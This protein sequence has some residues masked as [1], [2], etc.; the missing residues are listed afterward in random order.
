MVNMR[1]HELASKKRSPLLPAVIDLARR[2]TVQDPG[3]SITWRR[4][5]EAQLQAGNLSDAKATL[6]EAERAL[7]NAPEMFFTK[8]TVCQQEED[9]EG[10]NRSCLTG[11]DRFE[12]PSASAPL[13]SAWS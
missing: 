2:S 1:R 13:P 4:L 6:A 3:N 12:G 7:P 8:A 9:F 11:M 10:A 5:V